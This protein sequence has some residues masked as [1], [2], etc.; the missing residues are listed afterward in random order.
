MDAA[1]GEF[2]TVDILV[3]N[4]GI[5]HWGAVAQTALPDIDRLMAVNARAPCCS[6]RRRGRLKE[7]LR[8]AGAEGFAA[9]LADD[10]GGELVAAVVLHDQGRA[11]AVG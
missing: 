9:G 7:R 2:G 4:A 3:N 5:T 11:I 10:L 8:V 1:A 6:L